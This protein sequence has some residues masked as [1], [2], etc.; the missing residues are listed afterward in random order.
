MPKWI[1]AL[2][3]L[4]LL[5]TACGYIPPRDNEPNFAAEGVSYGVK[6]F[7]DSEYGVICYTYTYGSYGAGLSCVKLED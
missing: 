6:R 2:L 7:V 3:A 5:L 4:A 1:I